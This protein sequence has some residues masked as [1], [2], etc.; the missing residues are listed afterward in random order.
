MGKISITFTQSLL[1]EK[2]PLDLFK[3]LNSDQRIEDQEGQ[4]IRRNRV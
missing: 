4:V 3:V 2:V 1:T